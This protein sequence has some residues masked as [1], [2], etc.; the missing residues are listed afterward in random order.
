M[1][2]ALKNQAIRKQFVCLIETKEVEMPDEKPPAF[3]A[4]WGAIKI[5]VEHRETIFV[6]CLTAIVFAGLWFLKK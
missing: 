6:L 1:F 3:S 2:T 4:K 5:V